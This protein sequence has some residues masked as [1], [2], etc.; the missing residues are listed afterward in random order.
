MVIGIATGAGTIINPFIEYY[1]DHLPT[2]R[3][4]AFGIVL[5]LCGFLLQSL[6]YMGEPSGCQADLT[7]SVHQ[8]SQLQP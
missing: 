6:Q 3:L 4:G 5:I 2:Q 7:V 1:A 8:T